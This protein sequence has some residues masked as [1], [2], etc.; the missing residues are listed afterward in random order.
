[1][2]VS[3]S[4]SSIGTSEVDVSNRSRHFDVSSSVMRVVEHVRPTLLSTQVLKGE[5]LVFA[6]PLDNEVYHELRGKGKFETG[7]DMVAMS[8]DKYE[9]GFGDSLTLYFR[10]RRDNVAFDSTDLDG[11]KV[12]FK[13]FQKKKGIVALYCS[14]DEA[15]NPNLDPGNFEDAVYTH[16]LY[17]RDSSRSLAEPVWKVDQFPVLRKEWCEFVLWDSHSKSD[18]LVMKGRTQ[19][20]RIIDALV[21]PTAVHLALSTDPSEMRVHFTTGKV[22]VPVVRFGT[23]PDAVES[24][25]SLSSTIKTGSSK[26]YKAS[27]MCEKP[28]NE[29]AP[30]KFTDPGMLHEVLMDGL[31]SDTRYFYK[32]GLL[33]QSKWSQMYSFVSAPPVDPDYSFSFITFA[34]QGCPATG[35]T[36]LTADRVS[37]AVAEEVMKGRARAVHLIGDLSYADGAAHV[38]DAWFDMNQNFTARAP[39]MISIGNHD[40]VHETGGIGRDPSG[41]LSDGFFQIKVSV[42]HFFLSQERVLLEDIIQVGET[43]MMKVES[44]G[45][46]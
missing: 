34:D 11:K 2:D 40:Y 8:L 15:I 3:S 16:D 29:T 19:T 38:Y 14:N 37:D 41:K 30:G 20:F 6:N 45:C 23:D 32:V 24:L 7:L 17:K 46:Q 28:A 36:G 27:D 42:S 13:L 9:V 39:F 12:S 21:T 44:A 22:G 5:E 35:W 1:M 18:S 33:G 26:T 43:F 25:S 10:G 31:E 4:Y